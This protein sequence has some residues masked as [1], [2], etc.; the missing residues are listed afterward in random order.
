MDRYEVTYSEYQRCVAAG[1]CGRAGPAYKGYDG[2]RMPMVGANWF[3]ARQYCQW[4]GKR[5]PT[6]AEWEKAARGTGGDLYPW[7]NEPA[8]C[9]Q[10]I[11]QERGK[12]GCGTGKT[13][14]VGSRSAYRYGLF[15]MAGNSWEWV[16]DWYAESYAAC[17]QACMGRNP[18]GPCGGADQCPGHEKRVLKGGS[19]WWDAPF[20]RG[21]NR[22]P[23]F[24]RNRPYHHYGFRCAKSLP[25]SSADAS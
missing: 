21:S 8:I 7:G 2:P 17:G 18:K 9:Q 16:N 24:P 14:D 19:W 13:W 10:A 22:R 23:H 5:L 4:R 3:H 12:K 20:A 6:E 1:S 11:I 15:D 25:D